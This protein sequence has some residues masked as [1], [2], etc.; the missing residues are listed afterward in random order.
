MPSLSRRALLKGVAG[1]TVALGAMGTASADDG[2]DQ[3]VVTA[4]GNGVR[5]RLERAG[6]EVVAAAGLSGESGRFADHGSR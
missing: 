4:G 6:G 5:R 1:S 2:R 3:F